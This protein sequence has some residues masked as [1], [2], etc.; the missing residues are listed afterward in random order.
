MA[1]FERSVRI[2]RPVAEVWAYFVDIANTQAWMPD[3]V[4]LEPAND[5]PLGVGTRYRETRRIKGKE[6][7]ATLEIT[8][9][10]KERLYAGTVEEMGVRGTY[11]YR[12]SEDGGATRIDL[13]AEVQARGLAKLMLPMVV[14]MMKKQDGDQLARLKAAV[15]RA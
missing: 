7:T 1:G 8:A 4:R 14:G 5:G 12:F 15:E 10:E 2:E 9:F 3:I 6:Q 13:V 11:T